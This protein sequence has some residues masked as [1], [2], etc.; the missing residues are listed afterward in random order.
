VSFA[1]GRRLWSTPPVTWHD[2]T[3]GKQ[4]ALREK[5]TKGGYTVWK[6]KAGSPTPVHVADLAK[7]VTECLK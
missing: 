2:F 6:M 7:A 4:T 1:E 3:E 5:P